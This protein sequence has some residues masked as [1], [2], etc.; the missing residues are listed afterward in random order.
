VFLT[1]HGVK[2]LDFGLARFAL[3]GVV[4]SATAVTMTGVIAGTRATWRRNR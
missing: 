2:L 1:S 4:G 3:D